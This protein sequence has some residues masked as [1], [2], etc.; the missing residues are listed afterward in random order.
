MNELGDE[1]ASNIYTFIK[2]I[3]EKMTSFSEKN[4]HTK[5]YDIP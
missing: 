2:N 3:V 4:G 1:R 5:I